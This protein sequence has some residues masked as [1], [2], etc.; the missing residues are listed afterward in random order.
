MLRMMAVAAEVADRLPGQVALR[1]LHAPGLRQGARRGAF[2]VFAE[3]QTGEEEP[4][5]EQP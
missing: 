1:R 5:W 4:P 2:R 3:P